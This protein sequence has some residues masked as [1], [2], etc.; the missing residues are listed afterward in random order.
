VNLVKVPI[1]TLFLPFHAGVGISRPHFLPRGQ[2]PQYCATM[3]R[4]EANR[5]RCD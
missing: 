5:A 2:L 4:E 3:A 1:R